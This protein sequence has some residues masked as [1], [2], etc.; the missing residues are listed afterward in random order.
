MR[1]PCGIG[2]R[3]S[4]W[5]VPGGRELARNQTAPQA[6]RVAARQT[7]GSLGEPHGLQRAVD[8]LWDLITVPTVNLHAEDASLALATRVFRTGL[9]DT[10]DGGDIVAAS[11]AD[12]VA[13]DSADERADN[14]TAHV[15]VAAPA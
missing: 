4:A 14:R 6:A 13:E 15:R 12:L 10:A 7:A 1:V 5:T 2:S 3:T 11:A 9:L 8:A